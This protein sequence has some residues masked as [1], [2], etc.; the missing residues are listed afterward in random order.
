MYLYLNMMRPTPTG[1]NLFHAGYR[2]FLFCLAAK[3]AIDQ[4]LCMKIPDRLMSSN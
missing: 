3:W 1:G 2:L 4:H